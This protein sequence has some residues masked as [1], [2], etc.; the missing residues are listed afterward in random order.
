MARLVQADK[1]I[2]LIEEGGQVVMGPRIIEPAMETQNGFA[3]RISPGL[4]KSTSQLCV[5]RAQV[6]LFL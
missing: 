5:H 4:N 6:F 1:V 2:S 3:R